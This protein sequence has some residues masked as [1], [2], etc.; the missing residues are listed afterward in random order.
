[1]MK[2]F[3]SSRKTSRRQM[4]LRP[5][6]PEQRP[7]F[8]LRPLRQ[9]EQGRWWKF[10]LGLSLDGLERRRRRVERLQM[11][12]GFRRRPQKQLRSEISVLL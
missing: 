2:L 8:L 6:M 5:T 10:D 11:F 12:G 3:Y 4:P 1:M 9:L 7:E